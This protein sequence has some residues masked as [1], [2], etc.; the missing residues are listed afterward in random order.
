MKGAKKAKKGKREIALEQR[1]AAERRKKA[2]TA[3][4]HVTADEGLDWQRL[5]NVKADDILAE[6]E[7]PAPAAEQKVEPEE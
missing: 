4:R 7:L 3:P 6:E 5:K 1:Q 2:L